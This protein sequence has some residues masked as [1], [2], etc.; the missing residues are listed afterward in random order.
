M[1]TKSRL[2]N[3]VRNSIAGI[4]SQGCSIT[5]NFLTRFFFVKFLSAEYLGINGLFS[6]ILTVLSLAELGVGTAIIYSLYKPVADKDERQISALLNYYKKAYMII[7]TVITILGLCLVPFLKYIIKDAPNVSDL[8]IIYILFLANT[9]G[10]YFFAYRRAIFTADQREHLLSEYRVF[11][12]V[13]RAIGQCLILVLTRNFILYLLIQII[14]TLA[15]NVW[16]SY[17]ADVYYPFL[18]KNKKEKLSIEATRKI[19]TDI[20]SLMIY[21]VGSTALDGTDNI[22]LSSFVGVLW[23]GK[24]SNYTLIIS[25]I[26][27]M[28]SQIISALTASVGNYI[29]T[30]NK[31]RYEELL[32]KMLYVSFVI[33]GISLVCLNCLLT[34]FVQLVFGKEYVLGYGAV[35]ISCLN[36]YIFGMLN[37]IWTFRTTMGL[38]KYGKYRPIVS[39]IINIVISII[40]AKKMGLMGVLLGTTITRTVTNLWYDP[41][42]VYKH[43]L[44]KSPFNYYLRWIKY[45]T[46][47]MLTILICEMFFRNLS[48]PN[49]KIIILKLVVCCFVFW[50]N[51]I[52]WT[53]KQPEYKYTKNLVI[54]L[55]SK[56][57]K[58]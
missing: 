5:V 24:L 21:K 58:K 3:S 40:L 28:T 54:N 32:L 52:L 47:S 23:V 56:I 17:K 45:L 14:C 18:R 36:F 37:S 35:F 41:Y 7:G 50:I 9:A 2:F 38:F 42:I 29:A 33:Y 10:S 57:C 15:E 31:E 46:I 49:I 48:G 11:F 55:F 30:E 8:N 4:L 27:M 25:A 44:K 51:M 16:I 6:N 34:P 43:G 39:A 26:S 1:N 22:I 19:R 13:I 53:F 20:K 12:I